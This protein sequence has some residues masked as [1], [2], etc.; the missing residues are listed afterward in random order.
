[1]GRTVARE[2]SRLVAVTRQKPHPVRCPHCAAT[3]ELF[4]AAWCACP[5]RPRSKVC[6]ACGLCLCGRPEYRDPHLWATAPPAFV[7]EGFDWLFVAY[8]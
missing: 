7:K 2:A 6:R 8:L 1:M 5:A 3:F 4:E